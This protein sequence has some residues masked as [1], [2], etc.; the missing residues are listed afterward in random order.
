M[1]LG[2]RDHV[3]VITGAGRGIGAEAAIGFANEGCK[4]AVWDLDLDQAQ[5]VVARIAAAGGTAMALAGSVCERS[6]VQRCVD[7]VLDAWGT[8]HVLVNNAG[9]GDDAPLV[10]MTDDQWHRVIDVN[11][12]GSFYC[13]RAVAP[14]MIA[15]RYGRIVNLSS[16]AH[17]GELNKVNYVTAKAGLLGFTRA[18]AVELGPNEITV[19]AV[20]P[21]MVR[22]ARVLAQPGY[23]GLNE[24]A[25]Q[26][27][28]IKRQGVPFDVVNALLFYASATSGYV[29][30]D[31]LYV[32]GGRLS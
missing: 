6:D 4:V 26:R 11:L 10:E 30:G 7:A 22:T 9:F 21:G 1:D 18:L 15:Q 32:S 20:A 25:Q 28:L 2:I 17:F 24:R 19:N 31:V 12:T 5:A 14:A 16:R 13:A 23:A 27:Q 8:V 3:A 29:T